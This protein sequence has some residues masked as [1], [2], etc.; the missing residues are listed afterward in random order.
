MTGCEK[1]EEH[2]M[3]ESTLSEQKSGCSGVGAGHRYEAVR[4]AT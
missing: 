3:M 1:E 4:K 2:A